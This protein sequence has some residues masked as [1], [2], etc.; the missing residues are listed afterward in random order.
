MDKRTI[1]V[2]ILLGALV[3]FWFPIMQGL[4]L[5]EKRQAPPPTTS[6]PTE[7]VEPIHDT[8]E[9]E[10]DQQLSETMATETETT[11]QIRQASIDTA[12]QVPEDTI[13]IETN[14]FQVVMSNHGGA[15]ISIKLKDYQYAWDSS[16]IEMLPDNKMAS[17]EI[18]FNGGQINANKFV[19][20]P[21]RPDRKR[22][23]TS[24]S[25]DVTYTYNDNSGTSVVKRYRF[26]ADRYDFDLIVEV[27]NP[28]NLNLNRKYSLEWNN[29]LGPTE[30]YLQDDYNSMWAMA[31]EGNE[32]VKLDDY[33]DNMFSRM[34]DGVTSWIASR[35]K[36]FSVILLPRSRSAAGA[37][38]SGIKFEHFADNQKVNAR[39]LAIGL[40]M[41]PPRD[42]AMVD[43]FTVYVGPMDYELLKE[44]N[45]DV[46]DVIDIGTTP[47]VG[48]IIKIFAIPIIWLLPRMYAVIPNY[49]FVII[50][51]S[52]II[53]LITW[54]LTKKTV[55]SMAA[56]KDLQPKMEELKQKHKNNPQALNREMMK[57]Y[58]EMGINPLSG[59]LPYLP[60]MPLFFALFAVFRSTI[61]LRQAPFILWWNDLSRGAL[62]FTDPYIILVILMAGLM[63]VQQ[64][65]TMTDPK[66]KA[67]IYVMPLMMGFFFY[68]ASAGLVLYWTCF[69][70]FS[71]L[72]QVL[73]KKSRSA[74]KAVPAVK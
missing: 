4:G 53:K 49:G 38:A 39:K 61:L 29:K 34:D 30:L 70:L 36:Y 6:Q 46:V 10:L 58:K 45:S 68:K 73:F 50:I 25:V 23:I 13:F 66:N 21:S 26:Y 71:F 43:S 14:V 32:R 16:R 55:R 63:F 74:E 56:M 5:M 18:K 67:L 19:Y 8:P 65:M 72:E 9:P 28:E 1:I 27:K 42:S 51:F 2:I 17:P 54:P 47:F 41:E 3:I 48:W 59:C 11:P 35:S 20:T 60:Q 7:Q 64:K 69:S 52:L 24:G 33:K 15:P 37:K 62:S 40:V 44:V 31:M 22:L 57:L 12:T